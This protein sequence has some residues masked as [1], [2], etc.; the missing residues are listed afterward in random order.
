MTPSCDFGPA[1]KLSVVKKMFKQLLNVE[2]QQISKPNKFKVLIQDMN[3][4]RVRSYFCSSG[5]STYR[6]LF[7][8]RLRLFMMATTP[9]YVFEHGSDTTS[10]DIKSPE[11][12]SC[13]LKPYTRQALNASSVWITLASKAMVL[14]KE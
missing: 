14:W 13:V 7:S 6:D 8:P 4:R 3:A 9:E 11:G 1:S 2:I 12:A 10:E 5:I